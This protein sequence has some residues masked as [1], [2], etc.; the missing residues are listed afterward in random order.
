M[1]DSGP[2]GMVTNPKTTSAE[3]QDCKLWLP[4]QFNGAVS[5]DLTV[6]DTP[7]SDRSSAI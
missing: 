7:V 6:S 5:Y 3:C 1:I 2:V 4:L